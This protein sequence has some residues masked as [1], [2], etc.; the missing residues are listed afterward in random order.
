MDDLTKG[1]LIVALLGG[2]PALAVILWLAFFTERLDDDDSS[3][4]PARYYRPPVVLPPMLVDVAEEA[5]AATSLPAPVPVQ[6]SPVQA[7]PA[8]PKKSY[9][10]PVLTKHSRPVPRVALAAPVAPTHETS[11]LRRRR[12]SL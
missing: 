4:Q 1:I 9:R 11:P 8:R 5:F 10:S 2:A 7:A 12:R 6:Q 3:Y